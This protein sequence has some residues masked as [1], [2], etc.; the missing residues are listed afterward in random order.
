VPH[1]HVQITTT[2][3]VE[4][5]CAAL[6]RSLVEEGLAACVQVLGPLKSTYWWEGR[7][8][9]ATEF[10]CVIK[11]TTEMGQAVVDFVKGAHPYENPEITVIPIVGGSESYLAWIDASVVTP[12]G[13]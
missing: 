13:T 8:E 6:A 5:A 12:P 2:F 9:Q 4:E 7:I 3:D 1:S 11:T 10:M